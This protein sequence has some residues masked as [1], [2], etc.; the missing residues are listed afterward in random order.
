MA[1]KVHIV[2]AGSTTITASQVGN[3][4]FA[5]ATDVS[6]ALV[7]NKA[8]QT[9]T[10]PEFAI[11]NYNDADFDLTAATTSG[12]PITYV[13][14]N[15]NVATIVGNKVHIVAAGTVTITASQAGNA[16]YNAAADVA[17]N[18]TIVYSLP[19]NNFS[20]KATDETCKTSNN[21]SINITATQTLNYTATIIG[22][23]GTT[24]HPFNT[25]LAVNNLQ[26]GTYN[27]CVTIAGQPSYKQCFD[28]IIKEPKDLAVFTSLKN[29]GNTVVLKLEGSDVYRIDLNGQII[30]TTEQEIS[31]PLIKGSNVVKISSDKTCQGVIERTFLTTNSISLYPNPI[32]NIL[33]I[34]TGSN[35][36][37]AVKIDIHALDG[38]LMHTSQHRAEFGRVGVDLAKLNKGLYVLTLT[39]G[40]TKTVHKILKD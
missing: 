22:A 5:A 2:G 37:S 6:V 27:V 9:I 11:K 34:T 30:T 29:D 21:G 33:N 40:N 12:L 32:K 13:S 20:V 38:R 14:G 1:N 15:T 4:N 26:A 3:S 28:L 35:E 39:I 23:N 16:N 24:T 19:V 7:V 8:A 10:F 18:L 17:Q 36:T 31:L 25:T